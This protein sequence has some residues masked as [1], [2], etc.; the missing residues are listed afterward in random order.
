MLKISKLQTAINDGN[1]PTLASQYHVVFQFP[2]ALKLPLLD[3]SFSSGNMSILCQ[4]VGMP[5]IQV[6]TTE[7]PI[8]G[9]LMKMPYGL[10][11]QD[12]TIQFICTNDL[13]QRRIFEE[14]R[15]LV[16]DP[17]TNYVNYYDRYVGNTWI[18][19]INQKGEYEYGVLVEE[20]YPVSIMEQELS[21]QNN[22]WLRL[23]VQLSYRRWRGIHDMIAA[24]RS[25]FASEV[26]GAPGEIPNP[27]DPFKNTPAPTVPKFEP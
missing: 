12:L 20:V 26:P 15:R 14:W 13:A 1:G 25:K 11:Y 23:T 19:K 8:Y 9:P 10:A 2:D 4:A 3:D 24:V 5:G 17:T 27:K 21:Y 16:V 22:D 6:A 18:W 7:L